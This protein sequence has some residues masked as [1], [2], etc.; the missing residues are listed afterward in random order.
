MRRT[1][2]TLLGSGATQTAIIVV[3]G[4]QFDPKHVT[5]FA[6]RKTRT[7]IRSLSRDPQQT[8]KLYQENSTLDSSVASWRF[9]TNVRIVAGCFVQGPCGP[10]GQFIQLAASP[11]IRN[12]IKL[13]KEASQVLGNLK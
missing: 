9:V 2:E 4:F 3:A 6:R 13:I 7:C 10:R 5:S 1:T 12:E 11:Q 8:G